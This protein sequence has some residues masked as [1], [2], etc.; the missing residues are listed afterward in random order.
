MVYYHIAFRMVE[1]EY[2]RN[3]VAF[4][5]SSIGRSLPRI[6]STIRGWIMEVYK[7]EKA[8][9]KQE[10]RSVVSNIHL[11][12]DGWTSPNN[13]SSLSVFAHFINSGGARRIRLLAFRRTYGVKPAANEAVVLIEVISEY[14]VQDRIG[15]FMYNKIGT[16]DALTDLILKELHPT[17]ITKQGLSRRLRC[18]SYI[19]NLFAR[20]LLFSTGASKKLAALQ[21]K[22]L[23]GAVDVKMVF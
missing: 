21:A 12:F 13:Y 22:P 19:T 17:W 20:A 8:A 9:V 1:N 2:F 18:L 11:S 14:N 4:L 6:A 7:V 10:L 23:T 3:L 16:N 15:Y 5:S